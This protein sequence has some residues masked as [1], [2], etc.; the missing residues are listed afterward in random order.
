MLEHVVLSS[1]TPS[2]LSSSAAD[3]DCERWGDSSSVWSSL[4]SK[5]G[6]GPSL[7]VHRGIATE[8]NGLHVTGQ[9]I[10]DDTAATRFFLI[11]C[12]QE[13]V[14]LSCSRG[15]SMQ[16][17]HKLRDRCNLLSLAAEPGNLVKE[18]IPVLQ[19]GHGM[20]P[21]GPNSSEGILLVEH[22]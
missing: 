15:W 22:R 5:F 12:E 19:R 21:G 14:D 18:T 10:S 16:G 6:Q 1:L 7:H 13:G 3:V 17:V 11:S 9:K 8:G 20:E 4:D 2:I